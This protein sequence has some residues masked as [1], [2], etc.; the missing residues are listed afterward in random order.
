MGQLKSLGYSVVYEYN[1]I[2]QLVHYTVHCGE[3]LVDMGLADEITFEGKLKEV[4]NYH[5][6]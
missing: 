1:P 4:C 3:E 5:G 2:D 6:C